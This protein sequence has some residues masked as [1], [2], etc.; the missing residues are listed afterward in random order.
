MSWSGTALE[1]ARRESGYFKGRK[2]QAYPN[3]KTIGACCKVRLAGPTSHSASNKEAG[4]NEKE[5]GTPVSRDRSIEKGGSGM[6]WI[7]F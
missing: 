3:A 7:K 6:A 4:R 1:N 5:E 2:G